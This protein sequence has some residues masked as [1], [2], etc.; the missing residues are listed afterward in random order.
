MTTHRPFRFGVSDIP[1]QSRAEW[2]G[3]A[4]KAEALG[5]S[6]LWMGDHPSL[7]G[8]DV[9][10][11][12][13]AAAAATTTLRVASHVFAN[14]FHYP[15]LLAQAIATLDLLSDCHLSGENAPIGFGNGVPTLCGND[16][17]A[18]S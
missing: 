9:T 17:P 2:V 11:A 18:S 1:V 10:V 14:D 16:V 7:G 15:V 6:T 4:R 3:H 8:L 5:Y 12:L 13:M